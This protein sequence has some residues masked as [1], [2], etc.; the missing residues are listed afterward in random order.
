MVQMADV[1][2]SHLKAIIDRII[3]RSA[4]TFVRDVLS[5]YGMVVR[6]YNCY[7]DK[8][9]VDYSTF[10]RSYLPK[11][12]KEK[13]HAALPVE[14]FGEF[15]RALRSSES[16]AQVRI[17]IELLILTMVRTTELRAARWD[18]FDL[19]KAVWVIPGYRMKNGIEHRIP[20][21][22]RVICLLSDL[23]RVN[24]LAVEL[25]KKVESLSL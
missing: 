25:A 19:T 16:S 20:L 12:P 7:S 11:Q 15:M 2:K 5:Y 23:A 13:H 10:L 14:K 17:G 8:P 1:S 21:S 22:D 6:H 3:A 4:L 9:V 24:G 18:E